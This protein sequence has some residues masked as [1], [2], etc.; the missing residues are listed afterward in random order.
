MSTIF[1][2]INPAFQNMNCFLVVDLLKGLNFRYKYAVRGV[3]H[4]DPST[5]I[6]IE[7]AAVSFGNFVVDYFIWPDIFLLIRK[8]AVL[9]WYSV[10]KY[11]LAFYL[12]RW[13]INVWE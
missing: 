1:L 2:L 7:E 13:F 3:R 10:M 5:F 9:R 8:F 6:K 12:V 4:V 11:K